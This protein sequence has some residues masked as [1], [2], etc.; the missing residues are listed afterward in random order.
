MKNLFFIIVLV[1]AF[2]MTVFTQSAV[3]ISDNANLRGTPN[4]NGRVVDKVAQNTQLE[5]IKRRSAW[6]LVQTPEMVGWIHGNTIKLTSS[7]TI[8]TIDSNADLPTYSAKPITTRRQPPARTRQ[9]STESKGYIRGPRGGCY[10]INSRG[11]K[12]YVDRSLCN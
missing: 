8:E 4:S 7:L 3:V 9:V 6:F 1:S 2:S 11:N 5:I 12:T 10:Y